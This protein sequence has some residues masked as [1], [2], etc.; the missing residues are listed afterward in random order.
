YFGRFVL[1]SLA[2][3]ALSAVL[4]PL[5]DLIML[6]RWGGPMTFVL[7]ASYVL[8]FGSLTFLL[9]VWTRADAWLALLLAL[10][11]MVWHA[12]R[13]GDLLAGT[14]PGV[15][16]VI[17][18]LLPP[19]GAIIQIERAFAQAQSVPWPAFFFVVLYAAM[20]LVLTAASLNR[21]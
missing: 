12:L 2:A 3:F 7:I 5:F 4:M 20:I 19:H 1:L 21:R 17:T 10:A 9:S 14:P 13:R 11:A 18:L 8:T 15:R 16:E 6:G